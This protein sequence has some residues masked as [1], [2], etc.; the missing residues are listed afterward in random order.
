MAPLESEP[1]KSSALSWTVF[2]TL[3]Q[4]LMVHLHLHLVKH[5]IHYFLK[6]LSLETAPQ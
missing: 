6:A 4:S 5:F 1:I 3:I 2:S